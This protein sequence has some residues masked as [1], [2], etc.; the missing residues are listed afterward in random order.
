MN[1]IKLFENFQFTDFQDTNEYQNGE[2][3]YSIYKVA[4]NNAETDSDIDKMYQY[5]LETF[6]ED[7]KLM[8]MIGIYDSQVCNGG[9]SQ[10][11]DNGY[12]S[13][14]TKGFF[15]NHKDHETLSE[16]IRLFKKSLL[17]KNYKFSKEVLDIMIDFKSELEEYN[18]ECEECEGKGYNEEECNFCGGSG[19]IESDY[20]DDGDGYDEECEYCDGSGETVDECSECV[21]GFI[22]LMLGYLD[23]S[24]YKI[25]EKFIE[26]CNDFSKKLIDNYYNMNKIFKE[27]NQ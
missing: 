21:G 12:A 4:L 20:D 24:Y 3:F 27:I 6:G 13:I 25:S 11:W 16:M 23:E 2:Y 26:E 5:M 18:E 14:E 1:Y 15:Q 17:Y 10:Y 7:F 22:P 9:H 19:A 8:V